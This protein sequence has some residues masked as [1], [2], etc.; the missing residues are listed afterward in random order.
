MPRAVSLKEWCDK[1]RASKSF[2]RAQD[3]QLI[4]IQS[5][6]HAR[7]WSPRD[8]RNAWKKPVISQMRENSDVRRAIP[9]SRRVLVDSKMSSTT[10]PISDRQQN[11]YQLP[12][13][14]NDT[15]NLPP[16]L[17]LLLSDLPLRP[18]PRLSPGSLPTTTAGRAL[19]RTSRIANHPVHHM[20]RRPDHD[21]EPRSG[22]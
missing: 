11:Q 3:N 17:S 4:L 16:L 19:R 20:A 12:H 18:H 1:T 14:R 8:R 15:T 9:I 10:P 7:I 13:L 6:R 5:L 22:K 2:A 21:L